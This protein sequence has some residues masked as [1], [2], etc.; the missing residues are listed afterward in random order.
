[1]EEKNQQ[2]VINQLGMIEHQM[3]SL[4]EQLMAVDKGIVELGSLNI[5]LDDLKGSSGKEIIAPLGK[6]IFVK[7]KLISEDLIVDIGNKNLIKKDIPKTQELI[8]K[9]IKN[10]ETAKK[11]I[12]KNLDLVSEEAQ[13]VMGDFKEKNN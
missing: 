3:R 8:L 4:Q 2:E 1:M 9:Q 5:G 13:K 6:G 10:L 11:E 7:T 12:D